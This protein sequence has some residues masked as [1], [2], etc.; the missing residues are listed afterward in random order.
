MINGLK[1]LLLDTGYFKDNDYLKAYI[2]LLSSHEENENSYGEQHH[3]IPAAV[4][5][6]KYSCKNGV[7][8]RKLADADEKNTTVLLLYK[9]HILAH[10]FLYFC[11]SGKVKRAMAQAATC[12]IGNLDVTQLDFSE[13]HYLPEQFNKI[14]QLIDHI[15]AD[16]DNS[17]YTPYEV[18][19][20]KLHYGAMGPA[21]CAEQLNRPLGSVTAKANRLRLHRDTYRPWTDEE[22]QIIVQYY[23][24]CGPDY[25]HAL[26]IDRDKNSICGQARMLGLQCGRRY[27]I[28]EEQFLIENYS[29]LGGKKCAERLD[30]DYASLRMKAKKLG[31][32]GGNPWTSTELALLKEN[33]HKGAE[34]CATL[35]NRSPAVITTKAHDSGLSRTR[36]KWSAEEIEF[37]KQNYEVNGLSFCAEALINHTYKSIAAQAS[38]LG[39]SGR[40]KINKN[41]T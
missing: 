8:A 12:M 29:K 13:F 17:F 19:F 39:L 2:S 32:I 28:E 37:L 40:N 38:K 36:P 1:N 6:Y 23:E 18:E 24:S 41:S 16:P 31:L 20:L 3:I 33:Y 27:S 14:Q 4:Y 7:E 30:R 34:Y 21:Y 22:K 25:C 35:I 26:L 15:H 9:D 5:R 10:Y 11:T